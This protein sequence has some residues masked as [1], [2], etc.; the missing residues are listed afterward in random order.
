[1]NKSVY[2]NYASKR[3]YKELTL[4]SISLTYTFKLMRPPKHEPD[5]NG[6]AIF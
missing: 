6:V 2:F 5:V 3:E 4:K 1:M